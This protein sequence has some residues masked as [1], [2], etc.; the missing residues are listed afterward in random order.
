MIE[1]D[2][3][4]IKLE[5]FQSEIEEWLRFL[6]EIQ[7]DSTIP[8]HLKRGASQFEYNLNFKIKIHEERGEWKK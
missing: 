1:K 8:E 5:M 4:P 7:N 3:E 6:K 2:Y